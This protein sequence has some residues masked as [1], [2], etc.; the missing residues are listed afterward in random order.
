[1][2]YPMQNGQITHAIYMS[3]YFGSLAGTEGLGFRYFSK[4]FEQYPYFLLD[5]D[6]TVAVRGRDAKYAT[7][8]QL[9]AGQGESGSSVE[10]P[11]LIIGEFLYKPQV[12]PS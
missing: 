12:G 6:T 8:Q 4:V 1:M 7:F 10:D 9:H 2:Q 11:G 5:S 3:L